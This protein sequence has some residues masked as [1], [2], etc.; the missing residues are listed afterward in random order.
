MPW[1]W[2]TEADTSEFCD[3]KVFETDARLYMTALV[4]LLA[5]ERES[6]RVE[7]LWTAVSERLLRLEGD[8]SGVVDL[9]GPRGLLDDG[10]REWRANARSFESS[11]RAIR[12]LNRIGYAA[13]DA[14]LQDWA[15]GSDLIPGLSEAA[16][17][18]RGEP[19]AR[20]RVIVLHYA[21]TQRNRLFL[22]AEDLRRL[23]GSRA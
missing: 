11:L 18:L 7:E 9:S 22:L 15:N 5:D 14:H 4:R 21:A 19:P 10:L 20:K 23:A 3:P 2:H 8:L 16:S 17:V 1:W 13:R 12:L 6:L